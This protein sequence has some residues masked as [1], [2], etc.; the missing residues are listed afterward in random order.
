MKMKTNL[1]T[2]EREHDDC[3]F[4]ASIL[5]RNLGHICKKS[6]CNAKRKQTKRPF[7]L[8]PLKTGKDRKCAT[9]QKGEYVWRFHTSYLFTFF[10]KLCVHI[11]T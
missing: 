10:L 7:G 2:S 3:L 5:M 9:K 8:Y 1:N 4:T 11:I 6:V